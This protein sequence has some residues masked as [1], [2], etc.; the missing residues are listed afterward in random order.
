MHAEERA[1]RHVLANHYIPRSFSF[2][3]PLWLTRAH[4]GLEDRASDGA[5]PAPLTAAV[6]PCS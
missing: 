5:L 6:T 3:P 2:W 1:T 4:D